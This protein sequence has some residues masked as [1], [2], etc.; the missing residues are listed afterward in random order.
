M[1]DLARGLGRGCSRSLLIQLGA[2]AITFFVVVPLLILLVVLPLGVLGNTDLSPWLLAIPAGLFLLLING[3][4]FGYM[5]FILIR[6]KRYL[7]A[8]F[9]PLG[10]TGTLYQMFFRQYH[11]TV[12]GRDIS[13]YFYRGPTLEIDLTASPQTRL[14]I[15]GQHTDTQLAARLLDR[16]PLELDD[17][18]LAS[19]TV[20]ALD[21]D[22][23]R[24]LLDHPEV[25]TS[26]ERLI[27]FEGWSVRRQIILLPGRLR[28]RL[29]GN[30]NLFKWDLT[31]SQVQSW[32]EDL[33]AFLR[34][35]EAQPSP[36]YTAEPSGAERMAQGIRQSN[37][38]LLPVI[39]A[40][41][42]FLIFACAIGAGVIAF[43][44]ASAS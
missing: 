21:P 4:V 43:L 32:L 33:L 39:T 18:A 2:V 34:I 17:P 16:E 38:W 42:I 25:R 44:I 11:G 29:F 19:Y 41:I 13:V 5:A 24:R 20:F 26:L 1:A 7:D 3:G 35:A 14:T 36:E 10:L 27:H 23:A 6:R 15:T 37:P 9:E 12:A 40:V 22:W 28:L 30:R 8:V 31:T